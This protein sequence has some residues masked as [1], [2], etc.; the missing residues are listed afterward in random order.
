MDIMTNL[1]LLE[2]CNGNK[3]AAARYVG[4]SYRRMVAWLK[5]GFIIYNGHVY[6]NVEP[7]KGTFE[8]AIRHTY[9]W[10]EHLELAQ[11]LLNQ[12]NSIEETA[13]AMC[14]VDTF[15]ERKMWRHRIRRAIEKGILKL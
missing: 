9:K 1:E 12:T 3:A 7:V 15:D 13:L 5:V 2:R 6:L 11:I 14:D 10:D 4:I 8:D